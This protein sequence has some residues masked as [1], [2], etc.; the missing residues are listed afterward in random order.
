MQV[1]AV[2]ASITHCGIDDRLLLE[3]LRWT[4]HCMT[5]SVYIMLL[6]PSQLCKLI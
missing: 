2:T 6:T 1:P 4:T 3:D 5:I